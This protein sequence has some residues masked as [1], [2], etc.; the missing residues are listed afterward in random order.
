MFVLCVRFSL[1]KVWV[2]MWMWVWMWVWFSSL[3][4]IM[5]IKVSLPK[6]ISTR[7]TVLRKKALQDS[8]KALMSSNA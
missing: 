8:N 2:W 3:Y 5:L 1:M 4:C 6:L 7:K